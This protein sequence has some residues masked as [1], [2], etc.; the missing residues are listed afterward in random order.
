MA[1][2][3]RTRSLGQKILKQDQMII[4]THW[5]NINST[6]EVWS[7]KS[8]DGF[9]TIPRA[10]PYILRSMD[11]LSSGKP[12]S[13]TYLS[14]W[15]RVH[16]SGLVRIKDHSSLAYESGFAGQRAVNTWESRMTSLNRMGF[17]KIAA[18]PINK[19]NYV[20]IR[21]PFVVIKELK[22]KKRINESSFLQLK[23]R[24]D[25]VGAKDLNED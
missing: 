20:L 17:I 3:K 19:F 5:P 18:S 25:E 16:D 7:R 22:N 13:R 23:L 24:L 12:L 1:N 11:D 15:F 14:L 8:S 2:T 21:N 10:M 4:K 6:S 9:T